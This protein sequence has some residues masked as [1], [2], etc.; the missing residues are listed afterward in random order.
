MIKK[1]SI[2]WF[3][4]FSLVSGYAIILGAFLYFNMFKHTYD[5]ELQDQVIDTVRRS[6]GVLIDGLTKRPSVVTVAEND[7][8][9]LWSDIDARIL[10]VVYFNANGTVRWHR[11]MNLI[12]QTLPDYDKSGYLE[13][14]AVFEAFRTKRHR[15]VMKNDGMAYE[16][17]IPLKVKGDVVAGVI[18]IDISREQVKQRINTALMYYIVGAAVI[19]ALM[20]FILYM[21]VIRNVTAPII[22]LTDSIDNIS[23]KTLQMDFVERNDEIGALAAALEHFLTKV[24][25]ELEEREVLDKQRH[26]YEEEWWSYVLA[27]AIPKGSRAIVVDENNNI[28]HTNFELP[29]KNDGPVHLLDI[30]G[31]TQQE[32]V[33]I[34]GQAMDSPGKI[35]RAKTQ[36]GG[37]PF[38]IKTMQIK[39]Q[40][41]IVRTII[42]LEPDA[43]ENKGRNKTNKE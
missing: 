27:I 11:D 21:F 2:K 10:N 1:I 20:G 19:F 24:K 12:G 39:S 22:Y 14:D 8:I 34:V 18:S 26:N 28:M 9:R 33:Q 4:W 31:G 29:V 16:I 13:T 32:I 42:V 30:F 36:S 15:V 5:A 35:Y 41:G 37:K 25:R 6:A 40:G 7:A 43:G 17:A 3:L 23:T 38:L